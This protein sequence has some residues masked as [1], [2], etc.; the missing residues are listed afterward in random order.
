LGYNWASTAGNH[1]AQANLSRAQISEFDR[2]FEMSM[3]QP[4]AK[5]DLHNSF[6]Y[7][8][9]IYDFEG[10]EIVS[11]LWFLDSGDVGCL[12]MD[13]NYDCIHPDQV[14]WFRQANS[15]ISETDPSKG[16]GMLFMHIPLIEYQNLF[17]DFEFYGHA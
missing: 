8:L 15:D 16:K 3:T 12:G 1:E 7:V 10:D 5:P 2:S 13:T 6:N 17:N 4:N 9:P 14:N 11:R